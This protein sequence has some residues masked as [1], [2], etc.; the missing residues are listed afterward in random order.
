MTDTGQRFLRLNDV[1][2]KTGLSR[3]SIYSFMGNGT[4]PK[5]IKIGMRGVCWLEGDINKWMQERMMQ[6]S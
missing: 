4:F 3:S 1:K 5:S 2:Y 6:T